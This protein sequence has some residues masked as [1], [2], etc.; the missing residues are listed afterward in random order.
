MRRAAA[1]SGGSSDAG[2]LCQ[3][4][5]TPT[6]C[7]V[8]RP[9]FPRARATDTTQRSSTDVAARGGGADQSTDG[10]ISG[11]SFRDGP[12]G[13][14]TKR[15]AINATTAASTL[16]RMVLQVCA[17]SSNTRSRWPRPGDPH[18]C[19]LVGLTSLHC[20]RVVR[21]FGWPLASAVGATVRLHALCH[22]LDH[23]VKL[24]WLRV[25]VQH[26]STWCSNC[27]GHFDL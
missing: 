15:V 3:A 18:R 11:Q 20:S 23:C 17:S 4:P 25:G 9:R 16:A 21:C 1:A 2:N 5:S 27:S 12:I 7:R 6:Q 8:S 13:L 24:A 26:H 10:W 19:S 22:A 14:V